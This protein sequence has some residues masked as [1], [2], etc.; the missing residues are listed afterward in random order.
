[1]PEPQRRR[2]EVLT[3]SWNLDGDHEA[4]A[5]AATVLSP[6]EQA[7]GDSYRAALHRQRFAAGRARLRMILGAQLGRDPG[8]LAFAENAFGKPGL[9]DAPDL[10]FSLSHCQDQAFLAVSDG[11][12]IGADLEHVRPIEHLDLARRYFHASEV[13]AIEAFARL[14]DQRL[15]FF[16]TWTLKEAVV[17]A[18][19]TGLSTALDGFAI[20]IAASAPEMVIAPA[21][22]PAGW[23]LHLA[24]ADGYC[25]ALAAPAGV[26]VALIQRVF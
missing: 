18:L 21:D 26:Q 24:T 5:A 25:R 1:M 12:E 17:K 19:G 13:A 4:A 3:W 20:S 16:Q 8:P 14:D 11:L 6:E 2:H 9:V 10:R 22:E 7:R 23:W 15:A